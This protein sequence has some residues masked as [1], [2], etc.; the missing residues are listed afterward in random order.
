MLSWTS[1]SWTEEILL[2]GFLCIEIAPISLTLKV[3]KRFGAYR[4]KPTFLIIW[5]LP[6][7]TLFNMWRLLICFFFHLPSVRWTSPRRH[8]SRNRVREAG[9][10]QP[11]VRRVRLRHPR[12][13]LRVREAQKSGRSL[14]QVWEVSRHRRRRLRPSL[15]RHQR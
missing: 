4:Q 3:L 8:R 14:R 7:N 2:W 1:P 13:L 9:R 12:A 10:Q 15:W 5:V 11:R 6:Y